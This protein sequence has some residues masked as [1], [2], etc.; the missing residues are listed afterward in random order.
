MWIIDFIG[1]IVG[2]IPRLSFIEP[3]H[4]GV[5]FDRKG[6]TVSLGNGLVFWWPLIHRLMQVPIT[7]QSMQVSARCCAV[8]DRRAVPSVSVRGLAVQFR[9]IDPVK[10]ATSVL[11]MRQMIDNRCQSVANLANSRAILSALKPLSEDFGVEVF[12][13]DI[14]HDGEAL[15][16]L[17]MQA[18]GPDDATGKWEWEVS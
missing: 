17:L 15:A 11:D 14:T 13:A 9:I 1:F 8:S 2:I 18:N 12:R 5:R 6:E 10:A 16:F 7:V 4:C 3:T